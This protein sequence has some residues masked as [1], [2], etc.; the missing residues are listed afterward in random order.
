MANK[1]R[2]RIKNEQRV[3]IAALER[4]IKRLRTEAGRYETIT[5]RGKCI[6]T[7]DISFPRYDEVLK[8]ESEKVCRDMLEKL[9]HSGAVE[10]TKTYTYSPRYGKIDAYEF[11]LNVLKRRY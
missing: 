9:M 1:S 11:T 4:E 2:K 10:R 6:V 7:P 3:R 5:L 8:M